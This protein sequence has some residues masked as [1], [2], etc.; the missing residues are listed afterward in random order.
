MLTVLDKPTVELMTTA[1]PI[2]SIDSEGW[3]VVDIM[4]GSDTD[5]IQGVSWWTTSYSMALTFANV[6]DG[7]IM[8]RRIRIPVQDGF[9][10]SPN[11]YLT[12]GRPQAKGNSAGQVCID[13]NDYY[14]GI[15][16]LD[17]KVEELDTWNFCISIHESMLI[18]MSYEVARYEREQIPSVPGKTIT[19]TF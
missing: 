1:T 12:G 5:D 4:R 3:V 14:Y 8:H 18:N 16:E 9:L 15:N 7:F 10:V 11:K 2:Y 6:H 17:L 13:T 19:L